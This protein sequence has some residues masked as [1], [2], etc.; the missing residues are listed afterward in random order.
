MAPVI[1]AAWFLVERGFRA[2]RWISL[3]LVSPVAVYAIA[4]LGMQGSG[5]AYATAAGMH[6]SIAQTLSSAFFPG[7]G[8]FEALGILRGTADLASIDGM[9]T[10]LALALNAAAF[11]LLAWAVARRK[12]DRR[13]VILT[14]ATGAA[15]AVPMLLAPYAR[16]MY[17]GQMFALPLFVALVWN[18]P[19]RMIA[20]VA[21]A[22][23]LANPA[24]LGARMMGMQADLA[25]R[26]E[27]AKELRRLLASEMRDSTVR[28]VYLLNDV[29]GAYGSLAQLR[30]AALEAG[31]T[32]V[33]L[34]VV[35]SMG[36]FGKLENR[37][38]PPV[39]MTTDGDTL[40]VSVRCGADCDFS[41]PGVLPENLGKLGVDGVIRYGRVEP[42]ALDVAI[43]GASR[44]DW[45]VIGFDPSHPRPTVFRPSNEAS[46]GA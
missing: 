15:L 34:R 16:L 37:A 18:F 22:A 7:A 27:Q 21:A 44:G 19:R 36:V 32:D 5:G 35:N 33:D 28:R 2:G 6:R 39:R 14:V 26:N 20:P 41:F 43:P 11:A 42:R 25:A 8:A 40:R 12:I 29:P 38:L 4:K 9:R 30:M 46:P 13:L 31:R 24:W 23:L 17:L 45:R 3:A 1:V 10:A